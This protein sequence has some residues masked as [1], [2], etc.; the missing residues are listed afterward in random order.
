MA[1]LW[2]TCVS[3]G[4]AIDPKLVFELGCAF[5]VL[6]GISFWSVPAAL[7]TGGVAGIAVVEVRYR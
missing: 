4:K 2:K 7:I 1:F 6:Y 5:S 3:F